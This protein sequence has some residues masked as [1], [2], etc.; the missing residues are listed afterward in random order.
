MDPADQ[1]PPGIDEPGL[2]LMRGPDPKDKAPEYQR[3]PVPSYPAAAASSASTVKAQ[4]TTTS[5]AVSS[6]SNNHDDDDDPPPPL[7]KRRTSS[8]EYHEDGPSQ[9]DSLKLPPKG[10]KPLPPLYLELIRGKIREAERQLHFALLSNSTR[11]SHDASK[12]CSCALAELE[13]VRQKV[14]FPPPIQLLEARIL[15][16]T[17][18]TSLQYVSEAGDRILD[19]KKAEGLIQR[20]FQ[21]LGEL[22]DWE[23]VKQRGAAVEML[24]E[25]LP[26]CYFGNNKSAPGGVETS[27]AAACTVP[28]D[29]ID[30]VEGSVEY[31]ETMA[32]WYQ[33]MIDHARVTM[34]KAKWK[35]RNYGKKEIKIEN[36]AKAAKL[37]AVGLEGLE[38]VYEGLDHTD[39]EYLDYKKNG[40]DFLQQIMDIA[41]RALKQD[42][43]VEIIESTSKL[44]TE[45]IKL[46]I[47]KARMRAS[48]LEAEQKKREEEGEDDGLGPPKTP[49][50]DEEEDADAAK[51]KGKGK[52][53]AVDEEEISTVITPISPKPVSARDK[54][55]GKAVILNNDD[56]EEKGL[57]SYSDAQK[58]RDEEDWVVIPKD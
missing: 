19:A 48:E 51:D 39:S 55:K 38:E 12:R 1:P 42:E 40:G 15:R 28:L 32:L 56:G 7:Q 8:F 58:T 3:G 13:Y 50:G 31:T 26:M 29:E 11:D 21:V 54:G 47:V 30:G 52:A 24:E 57:P 4:Q 2:T 45:D 23:E 25:F 5:E 44:D 33:M 10:D 20:A 6:N 9:Y 18:L 37:I 36:Y 27:G 16:T 34:T 49:L 46:R 43:L 53:K 41:V 35:E 17:A 22:I 14:H